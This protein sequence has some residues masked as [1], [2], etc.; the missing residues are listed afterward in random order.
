MV[1]TAPFY[2]LVKMRNLSKV[3]V[4]GV[5]KAFPQGLQGVPMSSVK[6]KKKTGKSWHLDCCTF[7]AHIYPSHPSSFS[8]AQGL[9]N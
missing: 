8:C 9:R 4:E 3:Y 1:C 2:M 7:H 6:K 5:S